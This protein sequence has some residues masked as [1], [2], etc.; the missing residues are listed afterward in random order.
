MGCW[1]LKMVGIRVFFS[2]FAVMLIF[3]RSL[4]KLIYTNN[5]ESNVILIAFINIK[6]IMNMPLASIALNDLIF[7]KLSTQFS[8]SW[9]TQI[10][11]HS[12]NLALIRAV[13]NVL[14]AYYI[15]F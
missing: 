2:Q 5:I 10:F 8:T 15:T 6:L 7:K 4:A 12:I 13:L 9:T 3:S 1:V 11:Y 14:I